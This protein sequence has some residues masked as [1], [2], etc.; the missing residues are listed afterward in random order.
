MGQGTWEK[1]QRK[2]GTFR[3]TGYGNVMRR[4]K[5]YV[6]RR[7]MEMKVQEKRVRGRPRRRWVDREG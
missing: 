7:A 4:E 5:H 3:L 1:Y 2:P 6:G